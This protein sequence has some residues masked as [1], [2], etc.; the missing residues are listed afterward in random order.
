[1]AGRAV[2]ERHGLRR[3]VAWPHIAAAAV[4]VGLAASCGTAVSTGSTAGGQPVGA[5]AVARS[6]PGAT[7]TETGSTLLYPLAGTW[8]KAYHQQYP[9]V[10]VTTAATGSGTGIRDASDGAADVG[11][12]DAYL[13]SGDL[14]KNPALLNIPL[15]VSAQTVIYN[16]PGLRPAGSHLQLDG[17][18]LAQIYR[19]KITMWD[20]SA[21]A[22]LNKNLS[23]P[24]LEIVPIRRSDT[25]G[26]TFLFTSYLSTQD[27]G[28]NNSIG[29]GTTADW[30]T[31]PGELA[32]QGNM[33]M[34]HYCYLTDGCV[35]YDGI[36][37]LAGA[38]ADGLG[39][40]ALENSAGNF[41]LPT[42][43]AINASVD[44]FV[45][46]I[47]PNE[48]ISMI[49][50]PSAGGTGYPIINYEY[51]IVST[52]QRNTATARAIK[53]FLTWVITTGNLST[54]LD[55]VG[56]EPLPGTLVTLAKAQI[57]EIGS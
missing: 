43:P 1:V 32:E 36:S 51:A 5:V 44:S 48:T 41:T 9:G 47:P 8:A 7:I 20:D 40:A 28:W 49:D 13:S 10:I 37:Y 33:A 54:Y 25:S 55:R 12:S 38:K 30:P 3:S 17:E 24:P 31:V 52:K 27:P 56:F 26:D 39:E 4:I 21:I 45:S 2:A 11:A 22:A 18:V 19:G 23:L 53:D 34:L 16:V 42:P 57:A 46:L 29:Y 6:A 50:G 14:V 35:A 15:A